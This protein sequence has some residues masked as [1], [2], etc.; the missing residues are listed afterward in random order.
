MRLFGFLLRV[1]VSQLI[2]SLR[3][4]L[5]LEWESWCNLLLVVICGWLGLVRLEREWILLMTWNRTIIVIERAVCSTLWAWYA[6]VVEVRVH[7]L[8]HQ[9]QVALLSQIKEVWV[10]LLN[11]LMAGLARSLSLDSILSRPMMPCI[12]TIK[13]VSFRIWST[14]RV[15]WLALA[16]RMVRTIYLQVLNLDLLKLVFVVSV[17]EVN[18]ISFVAIPCELFAWSSSMC[19]SLNIWWSV[20]VVI[21]WVVLS[22]L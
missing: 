12:D 18:R 11:W 9:F 8:I 4:F 21:C 10:G 15:H 5:F 22:K 17:V 13:P 7:E 20:V 3:D 6:H 1:L 14:C 2:W 16:F 19:I